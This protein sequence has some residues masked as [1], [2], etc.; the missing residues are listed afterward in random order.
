M[1]ASFPRWAD[2]Y[3][4]RRPSSVSTTTPWR[5]VSGGASPSSP[6]RTT[7]LPSPPTVCCG[8]R[9]SPVVQRPTG[10]STGWVVRAV[11]TRDGVL[12]PCFPFPCSFTWITL[13]TTV[14][15]QRAAQSPS[16]SGPRR[17][18]S[19]GG[20]VCAMVMKG[21]SRSRCCR[22]IASSSGGTARCCSVRV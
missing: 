13:S 15:H 2:S 8:W 22:V 4:Q 10:I 12:S 17:T 1:L 20:G 3:R 11:A 19:T 14:L 5:S 7:R 16:T 9:A 18:S 21:P 6:G